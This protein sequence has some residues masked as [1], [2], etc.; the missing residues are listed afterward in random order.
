MNPSDSPVWKLV[1]AEQD[2]KME[3]ELIPEEDAIAERI[4]M[5]RGH[6][7]LSLRNRTL[8]F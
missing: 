1:G 2:L 3:D 6:S 5:I 8:R 7:V 4:L